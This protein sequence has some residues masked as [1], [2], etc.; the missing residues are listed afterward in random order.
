MTINKTSFEK[1]Y[2]NEHDTKTKERMLLVLNVVYNNTS[3][4]QAARGLNRSR[5]W[6][7]EWLK[8]YGEEGIQGLKNRSK[9]GR[10]P[11]ISEEIIYQIKKELSNSKQ[12][13][14]TKQAEDL[15]IQKSGIKYHYTHIYR[16]LRKWGF[17]QKVPR[18]VHVTTAAAA[19]ASKDEKN[20]SKKE[21]QR[22]WR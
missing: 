5:A 14:T 21:P 20:Y 9:S 4:A 2:R 7:S 18:K 16:I 1:I 15:I 13:W 22:Y 3:P 17:K 19:A 12:G 10:P 6:A 11:E 8:R